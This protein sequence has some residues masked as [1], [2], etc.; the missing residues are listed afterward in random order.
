MG[1]EITR[2]VKLDLPID[3]YQH[4]QEVAEAREQSMETILID[5][6]RDLHTDTAAP[7]RRVRPQDPEREALIKALR[8]AN[9]DPDY[10]ETMRDWD[11]TVGDGL[12]D[13]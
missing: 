8:E 4:L 13:D 11:V 12:R 5:A 9:K 3:V 6:A 2:P 7:Y 10:A 1:K